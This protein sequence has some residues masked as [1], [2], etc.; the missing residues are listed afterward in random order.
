MTYK[1]YIMDFDSA[2]FGAGTLDSSKMTFSADRLFSAL[3]IEAN[4]MGRLDE[5][6]SLA[7]Q[8]D[9]VLTDAFPYQDRPF[10]PKPIGFPKFDQVDL[11]KDVK[12]VRRQA[13]LAKKLQF[14]PLEKFDHYVNG[15]LFEDEEHAVTNIVTKN[16]PHVDG[17][18]YQVAT[19]R[20]LDDTALYVLATESPLLDEMMTSL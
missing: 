13:K 2:H 20:F 8:D 15:A 17:A 18:L 1:M 16:Q 5:F 10:L 14:I 7:N 12:E 6:L 19:T 9:F 4:K 11:N 3:V